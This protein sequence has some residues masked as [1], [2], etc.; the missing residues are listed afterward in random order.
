MINETGLNH[1]LEET[2]SERDLG[3]I[4][5][6]N[7]NWKEQ[8]NSAISKAYS[9]FGIL[10][11]TFTYWTPYTF[12][13]LFNTFVRPHLEYCAP[14]WNPHNKSQITA[15]ESV[16]R[17]ASK[18]VPS[19]RSMPYEARLKVLKQ[20]TFAQRRKRGD[21]IMYYKIHHG[22]NIVNWTRPIT[23]C[24]STYLTGP[25]GSVR[26]QNHRITKPA[27]G[28]C[29]ARDNFFTNRIIDT[30]NQLSSET[31]NSSTTNAFKNQIDKF[32]LRNANK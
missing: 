27:K 19:I 18:I 6:S 1:I 3:I 11:R 8:T 28:K 25:A 32:Y 10:K 14:V 7:L 2:S 5:D 15:L 23:N 17:K 22:H 13:I 20:T 12:K 9:A 21:Q 24:P 26:G 16:Q 31:I 29:A 30:W 4:I